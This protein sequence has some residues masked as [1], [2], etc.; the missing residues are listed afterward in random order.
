MD[1]KQLAIDKY[2]TREELVQQGIWNGELYKTVSITTS[3]GRGWLWKTVVLDGEGST[4]S[5]IPVPILTGKDDEEENTGKGNH[6]KTSSSIG[7]RR[8]TPVGIVDNAHPLGESNNNSV[9]EEDDDNT[10]LRDKLEIIDLDLSRLMLDDIFHD[11]EVHAEM[12][13]IMYNFLIRKGSHCPSS[14]KQGYHELLGLIYLQLHEDRQTNTENREMMMNNVLCIFDKLMKQM[15]MFFYNEKQLIK[16]DSNEFQPILKACCPKLYDII[17]SDRNHTN[18]L[19]LIRWTRLLFIRE[20]PRDYT[21]IIWDHILTF[22]YPLDTFVACLIVVLLL[23]NYKVFVE[24]IEDHNDLV[25]LLLHY[26]ER[27]DS[28]IDCVELCRMAGNL[29]E[30]WYMQDTNAMKLISDTFLKIRFNVSSNNTKEE[31]KKNN[32]NNSNIVD[33]NRRRIEEKLRKRVKQ[34]LLTNKE[35]TN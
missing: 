4:N 16:W 30:L 11:A 9:F 14:Y 31:E 12:R 29:C 5:L 17:C 35:N 32:N 33:P 15:I 6:R 27:S 19:W 2:E 24:E 34:T 1:L 26:Q 22:T 10:S 18:L 23:N 21:L 7:I 20:L 28:M 25:E 3:N 13:Q 8:L